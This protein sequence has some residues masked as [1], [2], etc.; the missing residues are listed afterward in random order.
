[1]TNAEIARLRGWLEKTQAQLA[2]LL[3]VSLR[4][5]TS[6]E[7]GWRPV[8]VHVERQMLLLVSLRLA[9][10][11]K[12]KPCW[13]VKRCA[14]TV[15]NECPVWEFQAGQM[16]WFIAGTHCQ[17]AVQLDWDDKMRLCRRCEVMRPLL[18]PHASQGK[19]KKK[20]G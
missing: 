5:V 13:V 20:T 7:Q 11:R 16:C 19:R 9:Q 2:Q 14:P 15:R 4:A 10:K 17:G 12:V 1:L 8:P 18:K 3:G 6:Y